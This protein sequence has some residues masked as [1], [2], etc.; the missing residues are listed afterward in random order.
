[1]VQQVEAIGDEIEVAGSEQHLLSAR[2]SKSMF[3]LV[4]SAL[5]A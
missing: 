1:M 5:Q 3:G 2:R 4:V